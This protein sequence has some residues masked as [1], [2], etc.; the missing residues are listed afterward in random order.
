MGRTVLSL[1]AIGGLCGLLLVTTHYQTKGPI[2]IN[3][4]AQARGLMTTMLGSPLPAEIDLTAS[5]QGDCTTWVFHKT[6]AM[7]YAGNIELRT[8]WRPGGAMMMRVI[9]H[10]ETPGIGDFI[11]HT[12]D[13]WILALDSK[14]ID[15]IEQTD[16]VSGATITTRA[17]LR[18]AQFSA[19]NI[20][21]F[22]YD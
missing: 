1:A 9:A 8:L 10:R 13:P 5:F 21:Q 18:A 12:R 20:E 16:N 19:R 22:C 3:R 4:E 11:D 17:I 14:R 6:Q 2:Q 15:A 7:G